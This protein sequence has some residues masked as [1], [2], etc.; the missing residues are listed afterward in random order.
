MLTNPIP[1]VEIFNSGREIKSNN[2]A[3]SIVISSIILDHLEMAWVFK[4]NN[5]QYIIVLEFII[6]RDYRY[7]GFSVFDL[8]TL[9][10]PLYGYISS[11]MKLSAH[12]LFYKPIS[13]I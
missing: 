13:L 3:K 4:N 6:M 7:C 1:P 2:T 5:K 8:H 12:K 9:L 11:F 10:Y